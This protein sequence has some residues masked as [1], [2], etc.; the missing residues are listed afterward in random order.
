MISIA[1][2]PILTLKKKLYRQFQA[3]REAELVRAACVCCHGTKCPLLIAVFSLFS[4]FLLSSSP[5]VTFLPEGIII[6]FCNFA[7]GFK[8]KKI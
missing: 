3:T 8:S 4:L 6:G 5:L 1:Y 2:W 7:W